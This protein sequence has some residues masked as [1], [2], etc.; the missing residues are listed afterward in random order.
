MVI[1]NDKP[2]YPISMAAQLVGVTPDRI[3]T[4][5][6]ENLIKPFRNE[7]GKRLFSQIDIQYLICLRKFIH[8]YGIS[9]KGLKL[10]LDYTTCFEIMKKVGV[11]KECNTCCLAK[12]HNQKN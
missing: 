5:E 3:R 11:V 2:F 7:K 9:V 10:L 1:E 12:T 8:D 4:Y 6:E